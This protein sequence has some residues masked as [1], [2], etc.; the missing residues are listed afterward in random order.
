MNTLSLTLPS[1][2][3]YS[4]GFDRIFDELSRNMRMVKSESYPPYNIIA[5][6]ACEDHP[7]M[8]VIRVALAGFSSDDIDVTET[9]NNLTI[10]TNQHYDDR[11][12][13]E[14]ADPTSYAE[15]HRGIAERK[16]TLS[17]QL[18]DDVHVEDCDLSNGMLNIRV[19]RHT[20]EEKKPRVIK[21]QSS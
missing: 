14:E 15:L 3:P 20:P 6:D 18:A 12:N 9:D 4:I 21:I 8:Y 7:D 17:F 2:R 1:F 16:F 5:V 13:E 19:Y 11:R 10:K